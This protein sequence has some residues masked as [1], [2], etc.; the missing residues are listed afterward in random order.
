ML[1]VKSCIVRVIA[2]NVFLLRGGNLQRCLR[3]VG[4]SPHTD[5]NSHSIASFNNTA[6]RADFFKIA[7]KST[8]KS[9]IIVKGKR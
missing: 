4:F 6:L 5:V 1:R 9:L 7:F 2:G 8:S 3:G